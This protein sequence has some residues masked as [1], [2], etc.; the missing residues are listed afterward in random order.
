MVNPESQLLKTPGIGSEVLL[1]SAEVHRLN[2]ADRL[3]A[4]FRHPRLSDLTHAGYATHR[5]VHEEGTCLMRLNDKQTVRLAPVGGDLRQKFVRR[6]TRRSGQ[7]QLFAY[8]M[9]NRFRHQRRGRQ[10]SFVL[11]HVQVCFVQ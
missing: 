4:G 2:V 6:D 7:I 11:R 10:G 1:Q 3:D 8:L 5:Q 9:A